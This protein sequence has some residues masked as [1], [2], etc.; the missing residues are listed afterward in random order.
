MSRNLEGGYCVEKAARF[1][2]IQ[3]EELDSNG[4]AED[5]TYRGAAKPP[6]ELQPADRNDEFVSRCN[7]SP[8]TQLKTERPVWHKYQAV[9]LLRGAC[10]LQRLDLAAMVP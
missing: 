6:A 7:W 3:F 4:W 8:P 10:N 5:R 2:V 9:P 1:L